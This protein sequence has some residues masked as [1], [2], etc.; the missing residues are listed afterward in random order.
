MD[1]SGP[2]DHTGLAWNG[3]AE[4]PRS[5]GFV[6]GVSV[7]EALRPLAVDP[8]GVVAPEV[9]RHGSS[10]PQLDVERLGD[11]PQERTQPNGRVRLS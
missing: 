1:V 11:D 4:R 9:D 2:K 8:D 3:R 7:N 5:G 6:D 10:G